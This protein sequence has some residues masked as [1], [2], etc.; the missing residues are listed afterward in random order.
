MKTNELI[1]N[2]NKRLKEDLVVI[3]LYE[4]KP[5]ITDN[6]PKDVNHIKIKYEHNNFHIFSFSLKWNVLP[7]LYISSFETNFSKDDIVS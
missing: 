5:N 6:L 1:E 3:D 2:M 7:N 4:D